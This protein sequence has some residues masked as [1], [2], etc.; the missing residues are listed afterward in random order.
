MNIFIPFDTYSNQPM[1]NI[2]RELF[3]L[4]DSSD[5]QLRFLE[6]IRTNQ[7][8]S[9]YSE[10]RLILYLGI[11]LFTGGIG[12]FAWQNMGEI[13]HLISMAFFAA[14]IIVGFYFIGKFA[15]PYSK[16]QVTFLWSILTTC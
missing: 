10:L 9:I 4:S 12:Y 7:I 8:V 2:Y 13:G 5:R 14:A 6:A 1:E 16:A 11:M 3:Q 15:K